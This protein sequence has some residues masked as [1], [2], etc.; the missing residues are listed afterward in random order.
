MK[1]FSSTYIFEMYNKATKLS[2][3]LKN[4]NLETDTINQKLLDIHISQIDKVFN[5][6]S[7]KI[8]LNDYNNKLLIPIVTRDSVIVPS[9]IPAFIIPV[10]NNNGKYAAIINLTPFCK[11]SRDIN[12]VIIN[13]DIEDKK[14]YSLLQFGSIYRR[15]YE[16]YN[17]IVTNN[18]LIKTSANIYAK[19]MYKPLDKEFSVGSSYGQID[20][21]HA[22]LAYF[23]AY[24]VMESK[25]A[26]ENA[27]NIDVIRD[28]REPTELLNSIDVSQFINLDTFISIVI[29]NKIKGCNKIMTRHFCN[30]FVKMYGGN[31]LPAM[32][33]FPYLAHL[34][35]STYV[36]SNLFKDVLINSILRTDI[37]TFFTQLINILN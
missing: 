31:A 16:N 36:G 19:L 23:F 21:A 7:K 10:T 12:G 32:E 37:S 24:N 1:T 18:D 15:Y 25:Y 5:I 11:I 3:I 17:K 30:Q 22:L 8:I 29:K 20:N 34:V 2:E 6:P 9:A 33:Y 14:L 4:I 35:T 27:I 13:I 26:R 28:K